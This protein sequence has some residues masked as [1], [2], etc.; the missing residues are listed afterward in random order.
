MY[1]IHIYP[2]NIKRIMQFIKYHND[3]ISHT[4]MLLT[5]YFT[6][7]SK[8]C[9]QSR[10]LGLSEFIFLY[11]PNILNQLLKQGL[12]GK[13]REKKNLKSFFSINFIKE[14]LGL[15]IFLLMQ[16]FGLVSLIEVTLYI[17]SFL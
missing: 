2:E 12:T 7:G 9:V 14:T 6:T 5:L 11:G 3:I 8:L 17:A 1:G 15:L 13:K 10:Y 4:I 16:F